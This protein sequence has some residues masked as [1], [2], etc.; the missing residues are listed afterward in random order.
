[1]QIGELNSEIRVNEKSISNYEEENMML[2]KG[3][4]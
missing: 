2:R 4:N 1:M 3:N